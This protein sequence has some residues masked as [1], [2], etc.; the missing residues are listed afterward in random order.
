MSHL[1]IN[2]TEMFSRIDYHISTAVKR[3]LI[4]PQDIDDVQQ[5]IIVAMFRRVKDFD[6]C[7]ATWSTFLNTII[8]SEI[9]QFRLRKRWFKH[10][11][12]VSVHDLEED[13]Q[14]LTNFYPTYELNEIEYVVF[15]GEI[16]NVIKKLPKELRKICHLLQSDAKIEVANRLKIDSCVLSKKINQIAIR[17]SESK[18]IQEFF[19]KF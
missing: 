1:K 16:R 18:I 4:R 19:E 9:R 12:F 15:L 8:E 11:E 2:V 5:D 10:Q 14:P 6:S 7:R 3:R 13:E 17:L